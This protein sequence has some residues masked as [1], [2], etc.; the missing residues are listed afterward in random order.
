MNI[1]QTNNPFTGRVIFHIEVDDFN[2]TIAN[3]DDADKEMVSKYLDSG[4]VA[5]KIE[6][7]GL[8]A[9]RLEE[10]SKIG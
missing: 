3:L 6:A 8:V 1:L 10:S 4:S 5:D 9:R 7:L 2:M